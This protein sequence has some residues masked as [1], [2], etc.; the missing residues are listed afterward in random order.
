M[1]N[2]NNGNALKA[3]VVECFDLNFVIKKDIYLACD[4]LKKFHDD[5]ARKK[6]TQNN[7]CFTQPF[8]RAKMYSIILFYV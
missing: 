6:D 4:L 1:S 3:V 8:Q 5:F 2:N 7:L